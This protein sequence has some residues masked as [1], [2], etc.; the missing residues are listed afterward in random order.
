VVLMTKVGDILYTHPIGRPDRL[1]EDSG[2]ITGET[3]LSWLV[4]EPQY[5]RAKVNKVSLD[6]AIRDHLPRHW[7]TK[8]GLDRELFIKANRH[9]ISRSVSYERDVDKLKKIA[10]ILGMEVACN[11]PS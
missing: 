8:E 11:P 1:G 10:E 6:E 2:E 4:G 3:R 7:Y 5:A 9:L